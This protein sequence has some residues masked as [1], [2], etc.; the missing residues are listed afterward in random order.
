MRNQGLK[1]RKQPLHC[2]GGRKMR[3]CDAWRTGPTGSIFIVFGLGFGFRNW[4]RLECEVVCPLF[5]VIIP[6]LW[7]SLFY[8][9]EKRARA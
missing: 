9:L 8:G 1:G 4:M 6:T 7:M 5:S 3:N 2:V